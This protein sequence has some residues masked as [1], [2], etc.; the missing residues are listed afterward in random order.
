MLTGTWRAG[1]DYGEYMPARTLVRL[2]R[3]Q[4]IVPT[5]RPQPF[6]NPA[7]LF[8]PKYDG[9]R[10][11][12]SRGVEWRFLKWSEIVS[13]SSRGTDAR[14][15]LRSVSKFTISSSGLRGWR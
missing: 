8:E 9:Y 6:S 12:L 13:W 1:L 7:W 14:F 3:V 4:P 15:A 10:G 11:L 5:A 2:P